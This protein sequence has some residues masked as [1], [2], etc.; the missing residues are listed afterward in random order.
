MMIVINGGNMK[1]KIKAFL[2][3]VNSHSKYIKVVCS[4]QANDD[5]CIQFQVVLKPDPFVNTDNH[6]I[7]VSYFFHKTIN[8][9]GYKYFGE[10]P[11]YNNTHSMF[12]FF[13]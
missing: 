13:V 3:E 12:W 5:T 8:D 9:T 2:K 7:N 4:A 1:N 11:R 6:P 10:M